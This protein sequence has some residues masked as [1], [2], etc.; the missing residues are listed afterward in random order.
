MKHGTGYTTGY[1]IDWRRLLDP[2]WWHWVVTIPLLAAHATLG[3]SA[4]RPCF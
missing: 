4:A 2:G 1:P 3:A